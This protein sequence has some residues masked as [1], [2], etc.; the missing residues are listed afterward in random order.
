MKSPSGLQ[1]KQISIKA[2]EVARHCEKESRDYWSPKKIQ[3]W[4]STC[5]AYVCDVCT[6]QLL[7]LSYFWRKLLS[8]QD[9]LD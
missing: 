7:S 1:E 6:I 5:T 8:I 2:R 3:R 9:T 4:T